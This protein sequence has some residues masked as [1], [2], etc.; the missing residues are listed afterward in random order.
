LKKLLNLKQWLTVPDAARHLS[1]FFGEDV[2]EAD[3]LRL[4]LEGHLTLSVDFVNFASG[5]CG[6]VVPLQDAKR[7]KIPSLKEN[8]WIDLVEGVQIGDQVIQLGEQVVR[9]EGV[10]DLKMRGAEQIDVEH[11]YQFLTGGPSVDLHS[12]AGAIVCRE[13]GTHCQLQSHFSD[14]E[15]ANQENLKKPRNHPDNYYPAG[16]LPADSVLVVKTSALHDLEARQS[17]PDQKAERPLKQRE[18][19]TLLVIIAALAELP[20]IDVKKPSKAAVAIEGETARM[21][22]RVAART[23]EDHLKRIPDALDRRSE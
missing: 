20:K 1:I 23:I 4:G 22:V 19:D 5:R 7:E 14:N 13:D 15:F 18:R 10:W 16:G 11:R 6:P 17:E 9:L 8:E 2:N 21:G 12:L 3:V